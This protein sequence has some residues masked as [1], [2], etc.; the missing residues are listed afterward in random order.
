MSA[1]IKLGDPGDAALAR[2]QILPDF[3]RGIADIANQ[4]DAGDDDPPCQ[5]YFPPFECLPM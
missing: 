3:I 5:N 4:A 1:G 2:E